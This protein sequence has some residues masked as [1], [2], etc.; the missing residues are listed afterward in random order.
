MVARAA[1][2]TFGTRA[3]VP[4]DPDDDEHKSR[5]ELVFRG[6][7]GGLWI[8]GGFQPLIRKVC[9]RLQSVEIEGVPVLHERLILTD[10]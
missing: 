6:A 2:A 3:A 4:F 5:T 7:E 9:A 10:V 8:A 1:R